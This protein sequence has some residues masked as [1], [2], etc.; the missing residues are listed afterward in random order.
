MKAALELSVDTTMWDWRAALAAATV[1]TTSGGGSVVPS[2]SDADAA[3]R[4]L[5]AQH[6]LAARVALRPEVTLALAPVID[7]AER[8]EKL[9]A[10]FRVGSNGGAV[11]HGV[12]YEVGEVPFEC[13]L[14]GLGVVRGTLPPLR[15]TDIVGVPSL[16]E[17][18]RGLSVAEL[19]RLAVTALRNS[20]V[21]LP[22]LWGIK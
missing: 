3:A 9:S 5:G 12:V 20:G 16:D 15:L 22:L 18:R 2:R 17:L 1:V 6:S 4:H 13:E 7:Q 19:P 10:A 11:T 14:P 8:M 21:I